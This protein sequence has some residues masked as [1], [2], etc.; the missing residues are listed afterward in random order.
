MQP[1]IM[2]FCS[3]SSASTEWPESLIVRL[4][5]KSLKGEDWTMIS[6]SGHLP[7]NVLHPHLYLILALLSCRLCVWLQCSFSLS[8]FVMPKVSEVHLFGFLLSPLFLF[9]LAV[10]SQ[11]PNRLSKSCLR[12]KVQLLCPEQ[13]KKTEMRRQTKGETDALREFPSAARHQTV[14][15]ICRE[16]LAKPN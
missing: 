1:M 10:S 9:D 6:L 13:E 16:S 5:E 15:N 3:R 14:S 8:L 2:I 12:A 7:L 4:K 11:I